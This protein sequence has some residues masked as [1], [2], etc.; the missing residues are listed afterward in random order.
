M[1]H[2][3]HR[4][5]SYEKVAPYTLRVT[6]EDGSAQVIEFL[7]ILKGDLY[8]P[9]RDEE[10]F[11]CVE[12]DDE[13]HTLVWP[14]GADFDPAI[15]YSWPERIGDLKRLAVQWETSDANRYA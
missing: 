7:P 13:A 10:F 2:E 14:N 1:P 6:F 12:L 8:G 9:L 4:V 3:L 11:D 15:L 5:V